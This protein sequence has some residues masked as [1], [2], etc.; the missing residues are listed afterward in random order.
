MNST[1]V[2]ICTAHFIHTQME[3]H[4]HTHMH[5]AIIKLAQI[6]HTYNQIYLVP[7]TC[8]NLSACILPLL[9]GSKS[10]NQSVTRI[11]LRSTCSFISA[12]SSFMSPGTSG[13]KVHSAL[14]HVIEIR[15]WEGIIKNRRILLSN[16]KH[17]MQLYVCVHIYTQWTG[18]YHAVLEIKAPST[19][20]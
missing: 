1:P 4:K 18:S 20:N 6:L 15:R 11:W 10:S 5:S 8:R 3:I 7:G 13:G 14:L 16:S 2:W 12:K 9:R 19:G 17:N